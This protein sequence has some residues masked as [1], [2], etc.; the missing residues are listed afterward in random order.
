M[1]LTV[2]KKVPAAVSTLLNKLADS[3]R[4][5]NEIERDLVESVRAC[6]LSR[7]ISKHQME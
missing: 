5:T 6:G 1:L 2:E 4:G 3:L 7:D